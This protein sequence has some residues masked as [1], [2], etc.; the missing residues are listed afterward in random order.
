MEPGTKAAAVM[1]GEYALYVVV[2]RFK[3]CRFRDRLLRLLPAGGVGR[4]AS[5]D[6]IRLRGSLSG[7]GAPDR[8]HL[9]PPPRRAPSA[10]ARSARRPLPADWERR[11][12]PKP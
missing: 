6:A 12:S 10:A 2:R 5:P 9:S 11:S 1:A 8:P 7:G 3:H 4:S